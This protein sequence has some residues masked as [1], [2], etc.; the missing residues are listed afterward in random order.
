M[1]TSYKY[2]SSSAGGCSKKC[3]MS[4]GPALAPAPAAPALL[5]TVVRHRMRSRWRHRSPPS[6]DVGV[7]SPQ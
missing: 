5:A 4:R 1:C 6:D 7:K 3:P 2:T